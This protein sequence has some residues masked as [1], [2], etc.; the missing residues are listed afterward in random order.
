MKIAEWKE[1][2][3]KITKDTLKLVAWAT[4]GIHPD[5][6]KKIKDGMTPPD[7]QS[8]PRDADVVANELAWLDLTDKERAVF[9]TGSRLLWGV[10]I[11]AVTGETT[12]DK[13]TGSEDVFL[14][15]PADANGWTKFIAATDEEKYAIMEEA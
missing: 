4:D 14:P 5:T 1:S 3:K 8:V 13:D 2:V 7:I 10:E 6:G 15:P 12:E 11:G 9:N